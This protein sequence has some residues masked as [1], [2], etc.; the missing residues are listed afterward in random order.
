M[1]SAC[2]TEYNFPIFQT[3]INIR[4]ISLNKK[5]EPTAKINY[6]SEFDVGVSNVTSEKSTGSESCGTDELS[7]CSNPLL[8]NAEVPNEVFIPCINIHDSLHIKI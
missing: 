1:K 2:P 3:M 7:N 8:L 4:N 5:S 6:A